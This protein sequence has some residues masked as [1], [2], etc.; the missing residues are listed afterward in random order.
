MKILEFYSKKELVLVKEFRNA[1]YT[2]DDIKHAI[3]FMRENP[4]DDN[5]PPTPPSKRM[6]LAEIVNLDFKSQKVIS[7]AK[8]A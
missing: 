3:Q 7:L 5:E 8:A 4:L 6:K 1:G 2:E